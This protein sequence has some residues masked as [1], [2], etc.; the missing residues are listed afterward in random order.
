MENQRLLSLDAFRGFTIAA[1]ILVNNPGSWEYVYPPLL[2]AEWNG[3]T[4]TDLIFP[5]FLFIVGVSIVLVYTKRLQQGF[6]KKKLIQK[7]IFRSFKIFAVGVLLS[8][9]MNLNITEIRYAGVLQRIAIVFLVCSIF[10]L[11]SGWKTQAFVA[12]GLL[13]FYWLSMALIPTPGYETAMLEPGINLA[14]WIDNILLPGQM[15]QGTWDPEGIFSTLPAIATG[16]TGMLVGRLLLIEI[17][18][19]RKVIWLFTLGFAA[20]V[21]GFMWGWIFPLNKNL[22]TSSYVVLTSG[23]AALTFAALFFMVDILGYKKSVWVGIVFG[24]N[25]IAIYVLADLLTF[26]FYS[27][28]IGGASL[29]QYFLNFFASIGFSLQFASF[30]YALF[31][32]G[33]NFIPAYFLYKKKIFI[34]L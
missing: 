26:V 4:P 13:L 8:I 34:K 25:A 3:L 1:M 18:R 21:L 15:W 6:S 31:Y 33:I 29:N 10:Y 32:I 9:I 16:I 17:P 11:Y 20:A 22:W 7:I 23:L 14:A 5:F 12:A 28:D 24:A 2:H 27:T 30:V 19:D